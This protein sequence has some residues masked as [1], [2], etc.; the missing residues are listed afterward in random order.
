MFLQVSDA[1]VVSCTD[2]TYRFFTR[3]GREEKKINAHEGAVLLI[4]WSH[5]G[6]ALL[7]TGEDGDVKLWSRNGNLRSCLVSLENA[8]YCSAWSPDDEQVLIGSGKQLMIKAT[9]AN[10][11]SMQWNAHDGIIL[12]ADWNTSNALIIS[13]SED[14]TYKVWDAF[15]RQ[16]FS[17][18]PLENVVTSVA[19]NPNGS[20]FIVGS[21][22]LLRLCDKVGWTH[23]REKILSGSILSIAWTSDGTQF[24][25]AGGNGSVTF[26]QVVDRHFEW[27]NN[28]VTVLSPRKLRVQDT[29]N[30]SSEDIEL[31]RDRIVEVGLGFDH[32]VVLTSSQCYVYSL[33]NLNTPII[34]DIRAAPLFVHLCTRHFCTVDQLSGIQIIS[35]EGRVLSSPKFQGF[36]SDFLTKEMISL[37]PD[38]VAVIDVSDAKSIQFFDSTTARSIGKFTHSVCDVIAVSLNQI[39]YG[40]NERILVYL[41]NSHDLFITSPYVSNSTPG[42]ILNLPVIKLQSHVGSFAFNDDSNSLTCIADGHLRFWYHPE[43]AFVDRDL[44]SV[45]STSFDASEYGHNAQILSF[46]GSRVALRKIDGAVVYT[47]SALEIPLLDELVRSNKWDEATRLCRHQGM[48][49]LWGSVAALA[50]NKKQ[51]E[52]AEIALAEL[53]EVA[54]VEYIQYIKDIPSEEGKQAELALFRRNYE[55]AERILLQSNP[56]QIS[57]AVKMNVNL[58]RWGRA[59]DLALKHKCDVD[60]V[61]AY[62]QQYLNEFDQVERDPKFVQ[63]A[64]QV[65]INWREI[66]ENEEREQAGYRSKAQQYSSRK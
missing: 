3:S 52:V 66:L 60:L 58:F 44:I 25:C 4:K 17:S 1:F 40:T 31:S 27:R 33:Q 53:S 38:T 21:F 37:S 32:L 45:V 15:G 46:T 49:Y 51:L 62:R 61:L 65:N 7:T 56:P 57:S 43:V 34:F 16:L 20:L 18:R 55:E 47:S 54:K 6:S 28:D 24:A 8:V 59:L 26:A 50:L 39:N 64:S 10:K 23:C 13:G 35:Y 29:V 2:G 63:I 19:W 12:C 30:E 36:R 9:Q 42:G 5:D 14:C 48:Q 22:N 11:K 41:D